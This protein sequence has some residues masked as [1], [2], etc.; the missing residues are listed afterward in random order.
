[1]DILYANKDK[2]F[3]LKAEQPSCHQMSQ[4]MSKSVIIGL[5]RGWSDSRSQP[6][7]D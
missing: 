1:M 5:P 2:E 7:P 6:G 3:Y 4:E